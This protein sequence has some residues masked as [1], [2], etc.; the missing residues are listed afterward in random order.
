MELNYWKHV[1]KYK[2]STYTYIFPIII[3]DN[4][5][6]LEN[7][8]VRYSLQVP[9]ID[10]LR[11]VTL[12]LGGS[13]STITSECHSQQAANTSA[14]S[15]VATLIKRFN[16]VSQQYSIKYYL[17]V[18]GGFITYRTGVELELE[19]CQ[20]VHCFSVISFLCSIE[21]FIDF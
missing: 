18:Q 1:T 5:L 19:L 10:Y 2:K 7:T 14:R 20:S 13:T 4:Q 15:T 6:S 9:P 17:Y 12:E 3:S 21:I 11:Q 16:E 8:Y